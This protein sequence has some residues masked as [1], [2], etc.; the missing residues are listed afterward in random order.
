MSNR[1]FQG[2]IHQMKDTI[3]RVIGVVDDQANIIACSELSK[4]GLTNEFISLENADSHD[5]FIRDG[6]RINPLDST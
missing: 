6:I 2:L 3:D 5:T 4:I 1:L